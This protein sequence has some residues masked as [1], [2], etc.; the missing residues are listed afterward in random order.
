MILSSALA[1]L[2]LLFVLGRYAYHTQS[3]SKPTNIHSSSPFPH[4]S[5]SSILFINP[6][7]TQP[8]ISTSST[9][10]QAQTQ[11]PCTTTV[12]SIANY[13]CNT[14]FTS[15]RYLATI[16][17]ED[18]VDCEGCELVTKTDVFN[19]PVSGFPL[20]IPLRCLLHLFF[21]RTGCW[22]LDGW[23]I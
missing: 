5:I 3:T 18:F 22:R 14:G 21:W 2:V 16:Y 13:P 15:T 9:L 8:T 23:K 20:A 12:T 6:I 17:E 4:P 11:T 1:P 19:C 10:A 7:L